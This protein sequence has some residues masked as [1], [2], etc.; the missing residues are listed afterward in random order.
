MSGAAFK[1]AIFMS[2]S[3]Q[4]FFYSQRNNSR[5]AIYRNSVNEGY[6]S[7]YMS[8]Y[9]T[10]SYDRIELQGAEYC[11]TDLLNKIKNFFSSIFQIEI[12]NQTE[13]EI[14]K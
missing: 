7:D 10:L 3:C 6:A 5:S 8:D 11:T 14:S 1:W 2:S 13:G 4:T 9:T 12:F